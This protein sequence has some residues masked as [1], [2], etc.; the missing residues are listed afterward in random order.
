MLFLII[1]INYC[2][3]NSPAAI[4]GYNFKGVLSDLL[5]GSET[6]RVAELVNLSNTVILGL[7]IFEVQN[8]IL[9]T[10]M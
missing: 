4:A 8:I 3:G 9:G 1:H 5:P 7:W 2:A 10:C 6:P